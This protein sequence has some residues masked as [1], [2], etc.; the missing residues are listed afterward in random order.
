MY[1][2]IIFLFFVISSCHAITEPEFVELKNTINP[3]VNSANQITNGY[4]IEISIDTLNAGDIN[5]GIT[6]VVNFIK[7]PIITKLINDAIK[8]PEITKLI[9]DALKSENVKTLINDAI[10]NNV[11]IK[12]LFCHC[13]L[14]HCEIK[15]SQ[16]I[17]NH[18]KK[19]HNC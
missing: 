1:K 13:Q 16:D 3:Y 2:R 5:N 19:I 9:N 7:K 12:D 15:H 11:L 4:G 10:K 18:Y 8:S 14:N 6:S 17:I